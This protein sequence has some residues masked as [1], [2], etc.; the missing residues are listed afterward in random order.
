[1]TKFIEQS[2]FYY[3]LGVELWGLLVN[4]W[5]TECTNGTTLFFQSEILYHLCRNCNGVFW[6]LIVLHLV[7]YLI[8]QRVKIG[9]FR[10]VRNWKISSVM[11][12]CKVVGR[13]NNSV[14]Q[15]VMLCMNSA[16][17][18]FFKSRPWVGYVFFSL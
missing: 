14:V 8:I 5:V 7:F 15:C 16:Y 4:V 10:K 9:K 6:N 3:G 12:V 13:K 2:I 18:S 1:M 11:S 17:Y